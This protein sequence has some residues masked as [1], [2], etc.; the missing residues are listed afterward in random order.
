[1]S[2]SISGYV[3]CFNNSATIVEALRSLEAQTPRPCEIF[4]VDDGSTDCSV[5]R[6]KESGFRAIALGKNGGRG[7]ARAAAMENAKGDYV[8][9]CDATMRL[10]PDFLRTCI[11][12]LDDPKVAGVFGRV[13]DMDNKGVVRRWR[14]RHL[15]KCHLP[16]SR[17]ANASLA[18]WGALLKREAVV[19]VGNFDRSLRHTEDAELSNR[20][21]RAGWRIVFEPS[22]LVHPI[23]SNTLSQVLE[24]YWRWNVGVTESFRV[25]NFLSRLSYSA[26]VMARQDLAAGDLGAAMISLMTPYYFLWR[27]LGKKS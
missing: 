5:D 7:P 27:K 16:M 11:G 3:P 18:T 15:F 6:A 12:L 25:K 14:A 10:S 1:M 26:K 23:L 20:L 21:N 2:L 4:L 24:R 19:S 22:A 8:L 17:E 13:M 9:A